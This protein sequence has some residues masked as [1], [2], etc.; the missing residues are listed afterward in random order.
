LGFGGW[1]CSLAASELSFQR[2]LRWRS[3]QRGRDCPQAGEN[4]FDADPKTTID[5]P[6][7]DEKFT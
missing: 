5:R 1:D 7:L 6:K 3:E 2:A 4:L